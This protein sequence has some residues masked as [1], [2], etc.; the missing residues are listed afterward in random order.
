MSRAAST[1]TT[2][3]CARGGGGEGPCVLSCVHGG[4]WLHPDSV[5]SFRDS[6]LVIV[7]ESKGSLDKLLG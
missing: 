7:L 6:I 1:E 3:V 5:S 4:W 2:D